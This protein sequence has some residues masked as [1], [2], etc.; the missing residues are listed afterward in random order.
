MTDIP[1]SFTLTLPTTWTPEQTGFVHALLED[2]IAQIE[3]HYG[4]AVQHWLSA[5]LLTWRQIQCDWIASNTR[6]SSV[7]G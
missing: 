1:E 2:L 4:A 3:A 6:R 7:P 5:E